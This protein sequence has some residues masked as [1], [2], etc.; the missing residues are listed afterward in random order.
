MFSDDDADDIISGGAGNDW[1]YGWG[2]DDTLNGDADNDMLFGQ[3]GNDTM[4][5][6]SGDDILVGAADDDTITGG[7]D[8]D[9]LYASV[10]GTVGAQTVVDAGGGGGGG[11][12]TLVN[13]DFTGSVGVFTYGDNMFGGTDTNGYANGAYQGGDGD[14]A[15]GSA[16]VTLAYGSA[17]DKQIIRADI[18]RR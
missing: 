5:G 15:N 1:L 6:G 10:V 18:P 12:V 2:G 14:N 3:D 17:L 7:N 8:D 9:V 13:E 4:D 16:Q 11:L